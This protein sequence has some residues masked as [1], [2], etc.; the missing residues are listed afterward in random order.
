LARHG[1][2]RTTTVLIVLGQLD[3]LSNFHP[4][5]MVLLCSGHDATSH[6]SS[7]LNGACL[8]VNNQTGTNLM[9]NNEYT[10]KLNAIAA[11]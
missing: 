2:L 5:G 11:L 10:V 6:W 8:S 4:L 9:P 7:F 1:V 3:R